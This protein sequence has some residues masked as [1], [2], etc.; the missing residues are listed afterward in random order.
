M[1][2]S[3]VTIELALSGDLESI[4]WELLE[5]GGLPL[6]LQTPVSR[7]PVGLASAARGRPMFHRPVRALLV[8]DPTEDL[9]GTR[10]EI[11]HLSMLYPGA[12]VLT[13]REAT[14]ER[15]I[16]VLGGSTTFEVVHFAGHAWYDAQD[17]YMVLAGGIHLTDCAVPLCTEGSGRRRPAVP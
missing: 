3:G 8:G 5:V 9:P 11:E 16:G 2:S 4:P 10:Q 17:A 7:A 13:G 15:V 12:T 14:L 6:E 1:A